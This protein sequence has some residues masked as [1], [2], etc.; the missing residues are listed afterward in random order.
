MR[1][2]S[3]LGHF[4]LVLCGEGITPFRKLGQRAVNRV[5]LSA[6][7]IAQAHWLNNDWESRDCKSEGAPSQLRTPRNDKLGIR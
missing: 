3:L 2:L 5:M 1:Y 6:P 7:N 4:L